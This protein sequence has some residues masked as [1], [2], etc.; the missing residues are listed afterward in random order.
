MDP[1]LPLPL[2]VLTGFLGSGKTT[3]L[4]ELLRRPGGRRI[5]V[6]VNEVGDLALDA[7]LLP[8][9]R[10]ERVDE[11]V[12]ALASGCICCSLRGELYEAIE[13]VARMEPDRI[14]LETSGL[15]DPA[16]VLHGLATDPH[17]AC[18]ARTAG[19]IAVVDALRAES[20]L[21]EQPEVRRQL[22]LADRVVLT[23]ADLAPQ[24]VD[25]VLALLRAAAP[26]CEVRGAA[27]GRVD[28]TWLLEAPPLG[29]LRD[30]SDARA[31]LHHG[32]HVAATAS[33][34]PPFV[35]HAFETEAAGDVE[36]LA[37]W[38]RLVT[39]L[40]GPRLLRIKLL[41]TCSATGDAVVLQ[42]AGR[43][44][45]PPRRLARPPEG[46]QGVR[47]VVIERGLGVDA[48]RQLLAS[49]DEAAGA[50]LRSTS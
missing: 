6:L 20:L 41:V 15:A 32:G 35:A 29:R 19:V 45:S 25:G 31:W 30:V 33:G 50:T 21:A 39:Q 11:D 2:H 34:E 38:L 3:V 48:A 46:W 28:P 49:L 17:L 12:L 40:D 42:S 5:A 36:A 43:A 23:K 1:P 47:G 8:P 27:H 13:R 7:Y 22:E 37:L 26:G 44:V 9:G 16:P 24:R 18:V 14:V 10:V 4:A